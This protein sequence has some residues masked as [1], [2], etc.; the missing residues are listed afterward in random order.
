MTFFADRSRAEKLWLVF[1]VVGDVM[2]CDRERDIHPGQKRYATIHSE[3]NDLP[4]KFLF[5]K[6]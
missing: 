4:H 2:L 5:C 6:R 1:V 3:E